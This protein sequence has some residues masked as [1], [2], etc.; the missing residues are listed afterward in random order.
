MSNYV[1]EEGLLPNQLRVTIYLDYA[2]D[3]ADDQSGGYREGS[4]GNLEQNTHF[5]TDI[6]TIT[7]SNGTNLSFSIQAICTGDEDSAMNYG[8]VILKNVSPSDINIPSIKAENLT[9]NTSLEIPI[10]GDMGSNRT[11]RL[12][13]RSGDSEPEPERLIPYQGRDIN[14]NPK[15][16]G[17]PMDILLTF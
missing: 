4:V 9:Y 8:M 2:G 17:I 6:Y 11:F 7:L 13:W 10:T 1:Y 14:N 5:K 12:E 16:L 15:L 3:G